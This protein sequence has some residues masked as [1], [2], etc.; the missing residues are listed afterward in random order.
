MGGGWIRPVAGAGQTH[1]MLLLDKDAAAYDGHAN[2]SH[3]GR[4]GRCRWPD[5]VVC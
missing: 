1:E 4:R 3:G 2:G 5:R